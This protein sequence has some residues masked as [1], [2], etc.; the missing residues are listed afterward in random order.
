MGTQKLYDFIDNNP[1]FILK[2]Q[3]IPMTLPLLDKIQKSR[4]LIVLLKL[5]LLARYVHIL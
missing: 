1:M 3:V 5:I 2:K 4:L